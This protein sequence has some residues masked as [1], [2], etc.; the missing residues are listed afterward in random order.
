MCGRYTLATDLRTLAERF[1]F[2]GSG[3]VHR[4]RY[5][6]APSQEVLALLNQEGRQP[7]LLRWG[8]IP[9]WAKDAEIG[10]RMINARAETVG[11][12]PTFRRPLERQ[13]CLILADGFYEWRKQGKRKVP[14]RVVLKSEEPFAFAGL[15]ERWRAGSEEEVRSCVIITSSPNEL[16]ETIHD[17]MPVILTREAEEQWLDPKL[18]DPEKLSKLLVPYPGEEMKAYPV[19]TMVN[20]PRNDSRACIEPADPSGLVRQ[21]RSDK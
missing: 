10:N 3:I 20:S 11:E 5:N 2:D 8:L 4:A 1:A 17:R 12:K 15:W 13:R 19:S 6:I 9:P 21:V 16:M 7:A 14:V 18:R